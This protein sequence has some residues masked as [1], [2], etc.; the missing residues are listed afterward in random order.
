[1][2]KNMYY[3]RES[4][5]DLPV[6]AMIYD[7]KGG[8]VNIEKEPCLITVMKT[9]ANAS[10]ISDIF[11][12][13]KKYNIREITPYKESVLDIFRIN[14]DKFQQLNSVPV[15]IIQN[16]HYVTYANMDMLRNM[17]LFEG[18]ID[19][20]ILIKS[21]KEKLIN[22]SP[23]PVPEEILNLIA[24]KLIPEMKKLKIVSDNQ[25]AY[26]NAI[27]IDVNSD[28]SLEIIQKEIVYSYAIKQ[29]ED[30]FGRVP[31]IESLLY[32]IDPKN[33]N[34]KSWQNLLKYFGGKEGFEALSLNDQKNI[35]WGYEVFSDKII[36]I[37]E[38]SKEF[39]SNFDFFPLKDLAVE[40]AKNNIRFDI[41]RFF[42][43]VKEMENAM[44]MFSFISL[45]TD[46]EFLNDFHENTKSLAAIKKFIDSRE[47]T[48]VEAGCEMIAM[49]A[50]ELGL[51]ESQFAVYQKEYLK[52]ISSQKDEPNAYP[53]VKGTLNKEYSWECI[54][55]RNVRAWFVGLE[56]NC[57]QHLH[58]L[59]GTCVKYAANHVRY[60]GIFRVMKK[61]KTIAQS[62]FWYHQD[63]GNFVLD[64]IEVLGGELRDSIIDCYQEF[65]DE[66]EKRKDIFGF[67]RITFGAGFTD[68]NVRGFSKVPNSEKVTLASMPGGRGVYSDAKHTQYILRD[69]N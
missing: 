55:M 65:A 57:C 18:D 9:K 27:Y 26:N 6:I 15:G 1:M 32:M 44:Q 37:Y 69:F 38:K 12:K 67:K 31:K 61:G 36:N 56:T 23:I 64:N 46:K 47:F 7:N 35:I 17:V 66:L 60:S 43:R 41:N 42:A 54:D 24:E 58:S 10:D 2:Q 51:N 30:A 20:D 11:K 13:N 25:F 49:V 39:E 59:G 8:E 45:L 50:K 40:K 52:S 4:K 68:I 14:G 34:M 22:L 28:R 5:I 19:Q 3:I 33:L 53:T 48:T 16:A 29:F 63:S 62:F 21:I